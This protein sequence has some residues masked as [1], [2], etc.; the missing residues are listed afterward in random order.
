MTPGSEEGRDGRKEGSGLPTARDTAGGERKPTPVRAMV[1]A[2]AAPG[3]TEPD[4]EEVAF[5]ANGR[6]WIV[7]VTGRGGASAPLLLLGF[8]PADAA[9]GEPACET[10]RPGSTLAGLGADALAEILA[11]ARPRVVEARSGGDRSSQG[12]KGRRGSRPHRSATGG[13]APAGEQQ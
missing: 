6:E 12:R 8:W 2:E 11:I 13:D 3:V 4:S 10:Y 7:R 1:N 5:D 9:E